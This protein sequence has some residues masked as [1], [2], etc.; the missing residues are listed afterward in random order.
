M[1]CKSQGIDFHKIRKIMR[2]D[3]KRNA[4]IPTAGFTAGPCLLKDTMQLSSFYNHKFSL[5]RIAMSINEGLPKFLIKELDK[6]YNLKKKKVGVLGL[7]FKG[8]TDDLRDSLSI[9][10]LKQLK[11]RKIRTFQSDEYYKDKNNID[12][13]LLVKK[14]DIIIVSTPHQAYKNLKIGKNKILVDIWGFIEKK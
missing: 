13:K 11:S 1:I 4:N 9:K 7:S 5:G 8:E 2:D 12:K 14:S 3:Y 10:L 6:V